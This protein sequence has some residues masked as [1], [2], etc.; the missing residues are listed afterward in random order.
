[1]QA[2]GLKTTQPAYNRDL[3][4]ILLTAVVLAAVVTAL[5]IVTSAQSTHA[6]PAA[7]T[8]PDANAITQSRVQF[9]AQERA[10]QPVVGTRSAPW[11][12]PDGTVPRPG[13]KVAGSNP[14]QM[15]VR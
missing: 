10:G 9:F 14:L 3:L 5:I 7:G 6:G 15:M 2:T 13:A 8:A 4:G 1:M 12:R 11:I